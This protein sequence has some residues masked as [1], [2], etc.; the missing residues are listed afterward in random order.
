MLFGLRA[1]IS[2]ISFILMNI[3]DRMSNLFSHDGIKAT[4]FK[5]SEVL[6]IFLR[7]KYLFNISKTKEI[8]F[9]FLN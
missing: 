8:R 4:I 2:Q 5:R 9:I 7:F 1:Y 6:V 3:A